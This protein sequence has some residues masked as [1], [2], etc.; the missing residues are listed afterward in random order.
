MSTTFS[1]QQYSAIEAAERACSVLS[2]VGTF[3]VIGTFIGSPSF[4]KPINRLAFYASWGNI[5]SNVATLISRSGILHGVNT[6]LCQFQAFLIQWFMPADAL[7]TFAMAFNVYLTF[8]HKYDASQLRRLEWK[9]VL[10]C[11]GLPFIPSFAYFFVKNEAKGPIYGSAVIWCWI[12]VPW[13]ILRIAVFYGPVWFVII[14]T[15]TIYIRAGKDIFKK[16]RQLQ[17]ISS[18]D[19]STVVDNP[20]ENQGSKVTEIHITTEAAD[21]VPKDSVQISSDAKGGQ[22]GSGA[23]VYNAYSVTVESGDGYDRNAIPMQKIERLTGAGATQPRRPTKADANAAAWAYCKYAM[24][25]FVALLVTW[26]PSTVN[27]VYSLA[28]PDINNFGLEFTSAFVL[29]LQGFWNSIIYCA[30]SWSSIKEL[31]RRSPHPRTYKISKP[32]EFSRGG[33]S[34]SAGLGSSLHSNESTRQLAMHPQID[35]DST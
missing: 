9:Y 25:Y 3:I 8:F 7:W 32:L 4:R 29:P 23:N 6:P 1:Q 18:A 33:G 19:P 10:L 26:V 20:F 21:S 17:N 28:H 22:R 30:I 12:S 34:T 2:L 31:L 27:R 15:F 35:A 11:Y 5:M 14:V 13:D 24:L 16:R